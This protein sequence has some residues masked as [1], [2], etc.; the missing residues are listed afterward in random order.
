MEHVGP[1][2]GTLEVNEEVTYD[3]HEGNVVV[4]PS[5]EIEVDC[6]T[7]VIP[8]E[9]PE[10]VD[11][12]IEGCENTVEFDAGKVELESLGRVLQLDVTLK[13]VCPH[14]RVALAVILTEVDDKGEEHKRGLKT[15]TVQAHNMNGCRDVLVRCIKFVLPE[16]LSVAGD[17]DDI[18]GKRKFKARFIAHYVDNDF[19]CCKA[20]I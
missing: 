20:T 9:C 16:D 18:C 1:C 11:I 19:E 8:E 3:D 15:V 5:P 13:R 17:T 2:T 7:V 14:K 4:F 12:E 10:P 6:G